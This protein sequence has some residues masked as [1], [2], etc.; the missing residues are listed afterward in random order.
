MSQIFLFTGEND[1]LLSEEKRRW[2][3]EFA[4]K[5]G[6]ENLLQIEAADLTFRSL[7][8]EV[9]VMPFV[10]SKR[11]VVVEGTPK[12]TKEE[13]AALPEKMHPDCILLF[14]E[15]SFDKR[16]SAVKEL[17]N[18][19]TV[20]TFV[21][22]KGSALRQWVEETM[23]K[24]G[25]SFAPEA[26][27]LLLA[28]IGEEQT[29]LLQEMCKLALFAPGRR[30]DVADI[31][32]VVVPWGE[33]DV[34][35]LTDLLTAGKLSEALSYAR[36]LLERGKVPQALWANLL[37]T[38]QMLVNISAAVRDGHRNPASITK[39]VGAP[40]PTV[41]A[42]QPLAARVDPDRLAE[43][44]GQSISADLDLKTGGLRATAEAPEELLALID[45]FVVGCCDLAAGRST[46]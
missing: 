38:L 21:P 23:R 27:A 10:A 46:K 35:K 40:F 16:L 32:E 11:L 18:I 43:F 34:W 30:L 31:E 33:R 4:E 6:P 19:A 37:W 25:G 15:A 41:R 39:A 8:D 13:I 45:Q 2:I 14:I 1:F 12:L 36:L 7:L 17:L 20:K 9:S 24:L 44:L 29:V 22:L 3:K 26:L 28:K 5:H 42:L